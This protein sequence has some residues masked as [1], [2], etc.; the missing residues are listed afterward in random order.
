MQIGNLE[1]LLIGPCYLYMYYYSIKS[2]YLQVLPSISLI[3]R[4]DSY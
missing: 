1:K 3:N 4:K 2:M